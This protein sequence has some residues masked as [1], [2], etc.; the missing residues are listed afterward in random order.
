MKY[1]FAYILFL[2]V[3]LIFICS[4]TRESF[5]IL[6]KFT[7]INLEQMKGDYPSAQE[8][9]LV[10]DSYPPSGRKEVSDETANKMWWRYPIFE[11]GSYEQITNN[12]KYPDNPDNARCTPSEFCYALYDNEQKKSNIITPLKPINPDCG[13]RIGYFSTNVNMLPYRTDMSNIL[14]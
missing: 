2:V 3:L 8:S 13:T 1:F 5:F 6:E 11:V 4:R 12:L 9:I 14:Y 7:G 10:Q